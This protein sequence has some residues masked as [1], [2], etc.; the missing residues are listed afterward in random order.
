MVHGVFLG[1]FFGLGLE[2][3]GFYKSLGRLV[4]H[5]CVSFWGYF[6][7]QVLLQRKKRMNP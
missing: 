6:R 1:I 3:L 5:R 4:R 2:T 7:Q